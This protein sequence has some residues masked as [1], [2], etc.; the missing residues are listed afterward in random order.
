MDL[1]SIPPLSPFN[2]VEWKL[3]MA[4]YIEIHD[5]LDVSFGVGKESYEDEEYWLNDYDRAYGIMG[6]VMS[7]YMRYLME[8]V[9]YP[10][11]L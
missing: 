2:Y 7:P 4:A 1:K 8:Y 5:L 10:F 3:N 11:E 9:E 6:M